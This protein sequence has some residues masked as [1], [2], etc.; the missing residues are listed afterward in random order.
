MARSGRG[1]PGCCWKGR[2]RP[3]SLASRS[4]PPRSPAAVARWAR[5][6]PE[7]ATRCDRH[8][9]RRS[10]HWSDRR[11]DFPRVGGTYPGHHRGVTRPR[12]AGEDRSHGGPEPALFKP[13]DGGKGERPVFQQCFREPV[14]ADYDESGLGRF[15]A[16]AASSRA[17]LGVLASTIT[18][19]PS[20]VIGSLSQWGPLPRTHRLCAMGGTLQIVCYVSMS[21]RG[22][23]GDTS[24]SS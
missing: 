1:T 13:A 3:L 23:V 15:E 8:S 19:A 9:A 5:F 7:R 24:S 12:H 21:S 18:M 17:P 20:A 14:H 16:G 6:Q 11:H 10:A 22:H 4:Q 2:P